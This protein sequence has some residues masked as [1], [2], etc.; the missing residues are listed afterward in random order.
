MNDLK[1][2]LQQLKAGMQQQLPQ[3]VLVKFQNSIEDLR[4]LNLEEKS[5]TV[6]DTFPDAK[7]YTTL[8]EEVQLKNI[9]KGKR[10]IVSFLRGSWC[11][12]C[13]VEVS[14]LIKNYEKIKSKGVEVIL[15]TPQ[16]WSNNEKWSNNA[17][18]PFLLYQ[19]KDNALAKALGISFALQ[20]YVIPIYESLGIDLKLNNESE[21]YILPVPTTY[22]VDEN[23]NIIYHYFDVDYMNRVNIED[24]L[25]SI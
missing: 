5:L 19:D 3:E 10:L 20:D 18:V 4:M 11:P 12:F 7:L 24:V 8:G 9:F 25:E 17:E 21:E 13:N 14:Y 6:D 2:A 1:E 15:I 22:I 23:F 16:S